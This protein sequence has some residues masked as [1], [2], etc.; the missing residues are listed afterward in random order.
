[1]IR[2]IKI[3]QRKSQ[4]FTPLDLRMEGLNERGYVRILTEKKR[5]LTVSPTGPN[6]TPRKMNSSRVKSPDKFPF[7]SLLRPMVRQSDY[8]LLFH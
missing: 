4:F 8:F 6:A 7:V 3:K 2:Y 1:M 5:I